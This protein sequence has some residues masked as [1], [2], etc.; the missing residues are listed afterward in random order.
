MA[1]VDGGNGGHAID[2]DVGGGAKHTGPLAGHQ[3]A[4]PSNPSHVIDIDVG[5]AKHVGD[6]LASP[7]YP[8]HVDAAPAE[9]SECGVCMEPLEWVAIGPC[10]H[11][12]VC[13]DCAVRMR[14]G[15]KSQHAS[16]RCCICREPCP[17]VLVTRSGAGGPRACPRL[18]P[19]GAF[20]GPVGGYWYHSGSAA[21][22][23]DERQYEAARKAYP[24]AE[25]GVRDEGDG[26]EPACPWLCSPLATGLF[27]VALFLWV[28]F[29]VGVNAG[30]I[31]Y[32][33]AH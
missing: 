2:M 7:A 14:A 9:P 10:G 1:Q 13:S 5:G 20:Q 12:E 19:L 21:Y 26:F 33:G 23:D 31:P 6:Q 3:L 4:S 18:P 15:S 24:K 17:T 22:F 30:V 25:D 27:Y 8:C 32:W 29:M 11:R 28:G 16:R